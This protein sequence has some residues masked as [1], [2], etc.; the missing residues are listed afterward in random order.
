MEMKSVSDCLSTIDDVIV[1][2]F[3]KTIG[4]S[5]FE[6]IHKYLLENGQSDFIEDR[7]SL[8]NVISEISS[9]KENYYQF[10]EE[11]T[12]SEYMQLRKLIVVWLIEC[13]T[14]P[15]EPEVDS[16]QYFFIL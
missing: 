9:S 15:T 14:E 7:V 12:K 8:S 2:N 10:A 11:D 3:G 1:E 16:Q 13:A 4:I 5:N 6:D